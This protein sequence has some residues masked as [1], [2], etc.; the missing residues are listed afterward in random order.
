MSSVEKLSL[1]TD[2]NEGKIDSLEGE[3]VEL[4]V[5]CANYECKL[6]IAPLL[7]LYLYELQS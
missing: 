3:K 2:L 5:D 4:I 7:P 6:K 1:I